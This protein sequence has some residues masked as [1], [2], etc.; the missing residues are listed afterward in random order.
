MSFKNCRNNIV[1][2]Q[3][4]TTIVPKVTI[5]ESLTNNFPIF[6]FIANNF[7]AKHLN[8]HH[9]SHKNGT[10]VSFKQSEVLIK[11]SKFEYIQSKTII[12]AS[13]GCLVQIVNSEVNFV[14]E[15]TFLLSSREN[16]VNLTDNAFTSSNCTV[17]TTDTSSVTIDALSI[18]KHR[19]NKNLI[20]ID[21][22]VITMNEINITDSSLHG[23]LYSHNRNPSVGASKIRMRNIQSYF[24]LF[25]LY[26]GTSEFEFIRID[27]VQSYSSVFFASIY[28]HS[29]FKFIDAK[30][31]KITSNDSNSSML[32]IFNTTSVTFDGVKSLKSKIC[33]FHFIET[34]SKHNNINITKCICRIDDQLKQTENS[35]IYLKNSKS[36]FI[37][38]KATAGNILSYSSQSIIS[39]TVFFN[40]TASHGTAINAFDSDIEIDVS[41][42]KKNNAIVA[43]GCIQMKGGTVKVTNS[44]FSKN[45]AEHGPVIAISSGTAKLINVV[46][47]NNYGSGTLINSLGNCTIHPETV[48]TP[49]TMEIALKGKGA[50]YQ[51]VD[52]HF[53]NKKGVFSNE[54]SIPIDFIIITLF[55]F[56][57]LLIIL[58][59]FKFTRK[60]RDSIIPSALQ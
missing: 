39:N 15:S 41:L 40:N 14:S 11:S 7:T 19:S 12:N 26:N 3:G 37:N 44:N 43:G 45:T 9:I 54:I 18:H 53:E 60:G 46:S 32:N 23:I 49:D 51:F 5:S 30:F 29:I 58:S 4:G 33:G 31:A 17:L 1:N 55:A 35:F 47:G 2:I 52:A 10:I 48:F 50:K 34:S 22:G 8:F 6:I 16:D 25:T 24:P 13:V 59:I 21:D 56:L 38:N 57:S 27:K 42:F 36:D 20:D 28:N